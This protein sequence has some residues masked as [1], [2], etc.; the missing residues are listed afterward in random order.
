MTQFRIREAAQVLGVSHDTVRRW[1]DAEHLTALKDEAGRAVIDG[2]ELAAWAKELANDPASPDH[3]SARNRLDGLVT[4]IKSDEVMS[5]VDLQ[6]GPFR[7][8]SLL[9][10][11][12]VEH[13][14]LTV[15]SRVNAVIK[16]TNV[17]VE[18]S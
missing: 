6:C 2:A 3:S 7:L 9:S 16:S 12:A 13:L 5:Q 10:T 1:V 14:G 17:I 18:A 11:E 15:G 8:V 4:A